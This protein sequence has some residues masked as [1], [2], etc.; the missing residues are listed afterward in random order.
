MAIAPER[1]TDKEAADVERV[2]P[3]VK[4]VADADVGNGLSFTSMVQLLA[5]GRLAPQVV[6]EMKNS[7]GDALG[8]PSV[9]TAVSALV[10]VTVCGSDWVPCAVEANVRDNGETVTRGAVATPVSAH[11]YVTAGCDVTGRNGA[12]ADR[13]GP[14]VRV[15]T[16]VV[17]AN[18]LYVTTTWHVPPEGTDA[19]LLEVTVKP[20]ETVVVG[21]GT[22][23]AA[24]SALKKGNVC[25][26][27][28]PAT[29]EK[30]EYVD[31]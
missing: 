1:P 4:V 21:T 7:V 28:P 3:P 6:A 18:R 30:F 17:G 8:T 5:V 24:A 15:A 26:W 23:T 25:D 29:I 20:E 2:S 31:V 14:I 22:T 10:T 13:T 9:T 19:Q 27:L 12:D 16:S 11:V